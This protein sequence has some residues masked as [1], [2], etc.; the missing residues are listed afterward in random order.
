MKFTPTELMGVVIVEPPRH[1]DHRGFL[2][3]TWHAD[4]FADGGISAKFV[5]DN[6]SRSARGILRGFHLQLQH[7]QGKLVR[8]VRGEIFDVAVDL[9]N[10][11]PQFGQWTSC[12]LSEDNN[13]A[14]WIPPGLAHGFYVLSEVA[15]VSYKCTDVYDPEHEI[16]LRWDDPTVGVRWPLIGGTAPIVSAKDSNGLTL[17][18]VKEYL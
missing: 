15:D 7:T 10:D 5:Q 3:E 14:L 11:S 18:Q 2:V 6:L 9:R 16:T 1:G 12:V 17:D 8:C 13:R 4:K